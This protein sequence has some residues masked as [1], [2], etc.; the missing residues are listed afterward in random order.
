MNEMCDLRS[1]DDD[2]L[3]GRTLQQPLV[4]FV[5]S[6]EYMGKE[7]AP[8]PF[9][10]KFMRGVAFIVYLVNAVLVVLPGAGFLGDYIVDSKYTSEFIS[11]AL[12]L[13]LLI[14]IFAIEC[15]PNHFSPRDSWATDI[16]YIY[17]SSG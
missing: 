8:S 7:G 4:K 1:D 11:L 16:I 5:S 2:P 14:L 12:L 9:H 10:S 17:C 13:L 15:L 6:S 3:T